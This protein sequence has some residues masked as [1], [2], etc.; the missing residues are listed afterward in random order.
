MK[1]FFIKWFNFWEYPE[2][3]PFYKKSFH[4]LEV[5]KR[6][7]V[8]NKRLAI[9]HELLEILSAELNHQHSS[10]LEWTIIILIII[11]VGFLIV[12]DLLHWI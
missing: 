2:I 3:E 6:V 5:G 7:E 4:Y 10:R 12:K 11:E 9:I 1:G 8:L